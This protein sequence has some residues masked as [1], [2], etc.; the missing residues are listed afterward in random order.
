MHRVVRS[1]TISFEANPFGMFHTGNSDVMRASGLTGAHVFVSFLGDALELRG[2]TGGT[3]RIAP[4]DVERA[5]IGFV[6]AKE[7]RYSARLWRAGDSEPLVLEP[8]P[9]TWP[10]YSRTMTA[11]VRGI[12]AENNL[13]RIERGSSM[14]EALFPAVLVAP[15]VVGALVVSA[16]VL[17][18]EPWWER[19]LL[20]LVPTVIFGYLLRNGYSRH[21]PR[22]LVHVED[23]GL[24]L[25]PAVS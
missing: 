22:R 4:A 9:G 10:A 24:V 17:T 13:R 15:L 25:P 14:Y 11:L 1:S 20:M 2:D 6:E 3:I 16:F 21:W 8:S 23:I 5:R 19:M 7:R 18:G 12:E